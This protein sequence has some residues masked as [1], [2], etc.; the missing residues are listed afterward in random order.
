MSGTGG[1]GGEDTMVTVEL[2][3][4]DG[5]TERVEA[6]PVGDYFAVH[7]RWPG[8][9]PQ[10]P[11]AWQVVHAATGLV[12]P[13]RF[14][15]R[16]AAEAFA[17]TLEKAADWDTADAATARSAIKAAGVDLV[18]VLEKAR[19][20]DRAAYFD[21]PQPQWPATGAEVTADGLARY[22]TW[23]TAQCHAR[24]EKAAGAHPTGGVDVAAKDRA[25]LDAALL[26]LNTWTTALTLRALADAAPDQAEATARALWNALEDGGTPG[27]LLWEW[28][29][30][31]RYDP[32]KVAM[33][34][35]DGAV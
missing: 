2:S 11:P 14:W 30:G 16:V 31:Y 33:D 18:G 12:V 4:A 6:V 25:Y 21:A 32:D 29:V 23:Q 8:D 17:G 7:D 1:N 15:T 5:H 34:A 24:Q 35:K 9:G 3:W 19:V 22:Y 28:L 13:A 10:D 20:A 26:Y 27:E